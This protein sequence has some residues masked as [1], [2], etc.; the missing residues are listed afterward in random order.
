MKDKIKQIDKRTLMGAINAPVDFKMQLI[1]NSMQ[2]TQLLIE[3]FL[4]QDVS[5]LTGARYTHDIEVGRKEKVR[6]GYNPSSVRVGDK[7]IEVQ[8]PRVRNQLSGAC[9]SLPMWEII[10]TSERPSDQLFRAIQLGLSTR[11]YRKVVG[12]TMDAFGLSKSNV[13]KQFVEASEEALKQFKER[14]I[15]DH[16]IVALLIDG[17]YFRD[18]QMVIAIG[19]TDKGQKVMLDFIQTHTENARAITQLLKSL[20]ARGLKFQDGIL[21]VLDGGKGLHKAV[22]DTFGKKAV[23]QRC[24]WHKR[25]NV[26]SYLKEEDKEEY[27]KRLQTAYS[28]IHYHT[29]KAALIQII[30]DLQQINPNAAASLKEGLEETLTLQKIGAAKYFNQSLSTTNCIENV[31]RLIEKRVQRITRWTNGLQKHRWLAAALLEIEP[32]LNKIRNYKKL[33]LLKNALKEEVKSISKKS[34]RNLTI[35]P[36]GRIVKSKISTKF[37]T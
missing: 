33:S 24:T 21:I 23:I 17:K 22:I 2:I 14:S 30:A 1:Q 13:S 29:A 6:H 35:R 19:I 18:D 15:S 5:S 37:R 25:E 31:N 34:L 3:H 36:A 8:V 28:D 27:R 32:R 10:K 12:D 20:I 16:N 11:D 7:K 26:I 9:E 4:E